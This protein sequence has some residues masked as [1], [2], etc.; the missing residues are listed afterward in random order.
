MQLQAMAPSR[1]EYH[2]D[3]CSLD[4]QHLE[5]CK[6]L[7]QMHFNLESALCAAWLMHLPDSLY[8]CICKFSECRLAARPWR[9]R[10]ERRRPLALL[11]WQH[12][13]GALAAAW[14]LGRAATAVAPPNAGWALHHHRMHLLQVSR[15]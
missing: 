4:S 6:G 13:E 2:V 14:R 12:D 10:D 7:A 8:P 5:V 11:E 15:R 1:C 9:S 3:P